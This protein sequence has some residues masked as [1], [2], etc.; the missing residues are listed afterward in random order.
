MNPSLKLWDDSLAA[1]L[2]LAS[3]IYRVPEKGEH[4]PLRLSV[5]ERIVSPA[6]SLDLD[7]DLIRGT[8]GDLSRTG[9]PALADAILS[10]ARVGGNPHATAVDEHRRHAQR[11]RDIEAAIVP[12]IEFG[13][14][15][16]PTP[17]DG[18]VSNSRL[19]RQG[20]GCDH[21]CQTQRDQQPV[22]PLQQGN[23]G[24]HG[25]LPGTGFGAASSRC[26]TSTRAQSWNSR[27]NHSAKYTDRC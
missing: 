10:R 5:R 8:D 15:L 4:Q 11:S 13:K 17:D 27:P 7:A 25:L 18:L 22:A 20:K 12:Q 1:L 14:E 26:R 2:G 3:I 24:D 23:P 21:T 16:A 9:Q 6:R 19:P